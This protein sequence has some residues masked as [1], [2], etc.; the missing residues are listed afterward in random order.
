[1]SGW[2]AG[3]LREPAL[4][5]QGEIDGTSHDAAVAA[6]AFAGT[7]RERY[8]AW[9]A[10]RVQGGTDGEAEAELGMRRSSVCARRNELMK[11]QRVVAR[12]TRRG[13]CQVFEAMR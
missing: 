6:D 8:Y 1:M 4:P 2:H 13:G 12:A 7:Q 10:G 3:T 5:W 9:L 11:Q